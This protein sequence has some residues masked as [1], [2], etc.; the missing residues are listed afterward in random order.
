MIGVESLRL[1]HNSEGFV[2]HANQII[3]RLAHKMQSAFERA[4]AAIIISRIENDIRVRK[5]V[6]TW[7]ARRDA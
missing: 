6:K 5:I 7:I 3:K 4:D 2:K 1:R